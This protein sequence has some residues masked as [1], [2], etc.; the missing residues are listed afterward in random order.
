MNKQTLK[1]FTIGLLLVSCIFLSTSQ[2]LL[3]S[4][5]DLDQAYPEA[6]KSYTVFYDGANIL[7][8]PTTIQV[9]DMIVWQNNGTVKILL[10]QEVGF[11]VFLPLVQTSNNGS[12]Q[13]TNNVEASSTTDPATVANEQ[14]VTIA[15]WTIEPGESITIRYKNANLY[16]IRVIADSILSWSM[17]V[18]N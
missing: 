10:E 17:V 5:L 3:A 4:G 7:D 13:S 8:A 12:N 2:T 16:N 6:S 9:D 15:A 18:T 1:Q 14:K 11:R